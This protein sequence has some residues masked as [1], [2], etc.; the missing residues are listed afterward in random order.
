[1]DHVLI[2]RL[3]HLTGSARA[4]SLGCAVEMRDRPGPAFKGGSAPDETVWIQL[5]GGLF[6][7]KA[8]IELGWVGEYSDVREVRARTRGT[9]IHDVEDF[10]AGRPRVGYA[11]VAKLRRESWVEP[12]WA[13][14]RTY[15][16][17]WV[18]LDAD[19]K[20]DSWLTPKEPPRSGEGLLGEFRDWLGARGGA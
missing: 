13:G 14:P 4:P 17:E 11:A 19:A 15:S 12:F 2:R 3:E 16:Y 7:A 18:L 1:V 6:V 20:R 10:W 5:R 8:R 9:P